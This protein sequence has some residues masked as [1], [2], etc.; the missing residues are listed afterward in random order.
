MTL[1]DLAA[2]RV[3]QVKAYKD[4]GDTPT[5]AI[6]DI[7]NDLVSER[8]DIVKQIQSKIETDNYLLP[9]P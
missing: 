1:S 9:I 4:V 7:I 8:A 3:M 5:D 6:Q 2:V